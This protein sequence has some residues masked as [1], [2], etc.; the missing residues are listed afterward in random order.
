MVKVDKQKVQGDEANGSLFRRPPLG[1][2]LGLLPRLAT[3]IC[4]TLK[5]GGFTI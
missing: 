3:V 4:G 2:P 5:N 1:Q